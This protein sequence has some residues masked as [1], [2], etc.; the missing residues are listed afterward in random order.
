MAIIT[1]Q[2]WKDS[3]NEWTDPEIVGE[4]LCLYVL[5]G[6][7]LFPEEELARI[8]QGKAVNCDKVTFQGH[9]DFAQCDRITTAMKR[10]ERRSYEV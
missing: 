1:M 5:Q 6:N 4:A 8:K 2:I 9:L 7:K 10:M 3:S